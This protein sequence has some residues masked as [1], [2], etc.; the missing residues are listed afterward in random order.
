MVIRS[1]TTPK[2]SIANIL[3]V[4]PKPVWISSA[5]STMPCSSHSARSQLHGL[6]LDHV[7]AAFALHRLEHD[8]RD[9][10][11]LDVGLEEVLHGLLRPRRGWRSGRGRARGRSRAGRA[12]SRPCRAAPC[13]SARRRTAMR[14]WKAPP[15]A[16]TPLRL[17][18]ARAILIAFSIASAP[19]ENSAVFFA[20]VPGVSCVQLLGQRDV[21]LVRHDLVAGVREALAAAPRSPPAPSGGRGRRSSPRCRRRSRCS[22][23]PRRPTARRSR[24]G[25]R[26]SSPITP[27][28]RGVAAALRAISCSFLEWFMAPPWW[29][30]QAAAADPAPPVRQRCPSRGAPRRYGW[31]VD[32]QP[33]GLQL[34]VL[35]EARAA[36]C[37]GRCRSACSRRTAP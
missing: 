25:R 17:V 5:I 1:G 7:E 18:W 3:P 26:R 30:S 37:R 14:P 9:A 24:R 20:C 35:V 34:G 12:R 8:G 16:I 11:R 15:K 32:A 19:V 21:A 28:P 6:G 10:A 23:G 13:R 29:V 27:T 31:S 4:R 2:C 33:G 36:T 22:A